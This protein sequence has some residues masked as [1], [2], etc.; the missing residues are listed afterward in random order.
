MDTTLGIREIMEDLSTL[1]AGSQASEVLANLLS[2]CRPRR[3]C[4]ETC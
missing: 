2:Q 3:T 1:I 4:N